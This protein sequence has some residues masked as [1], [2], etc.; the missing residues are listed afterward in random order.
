MSLKHYEKREVKIEDSQSHKAKDYVVSTLFNT[1]LFVMMSFVTKGINLVFNVLIARI[2]TKESYGLATVYFNFIF[3]LLLYFPRET[4]RKTCLKFCPDENE[5]IENFKFRHACHLI[6]L[7]NFLVL[8]CSIPISL[9]FI[10]FAGSGSSR[11]SEYKIHIFIF[12]LSAMI[13]LVAEPAIIYLNVKIDKKYRLIGMTIANYSRLILNY[14]LAYFFG[15]DLWSF[16]LSRLLASIIFAVYIIYVGI[17]IF[18]MHYTAFMPDYQGIVGITKHT[19]IKSLL[20]SFIKGTSLKMILN[21]SERIVLS[22]FLQIS[23]SAKAEYAFVVEN[24]STFIR[25]IIEPAEENFYNLINKIKNYK[26]LTVIPSTG[27]E[28]SGDFSKK[29][30]EILIKLYS[31]L[32]KKGKKDKEN[33]SFKLLKLSLKLFFV[34][35]IL[36]FCY[37]YIIGKD[38][39]TFIFTEKWGTEHTI[40]IIKVYSFY[41]G[42]L[43]ITS[44]TEAYSNATC[45]SEKMSILNSLMVVNAILLVSLSL[46]LSQYDITGLVWANILTLLLRFF[47]NLYLIISNELEDQFNCNK[48]SSLP[49]EDNQ[50]LLDDEEKDS[51]PCVQDLS[52]NEC[53]TWTNILSEMARFTYKSFMKTAAYISTLICL[54]ILNIIKELLQYDDNKPLLLISSGIILSLNVILIFM[55]EKKGFVEIIRLKSSG[56]KI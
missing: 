51:L 4:M 8:V 3:L 52:I 12:V 14:L 48:C 50:L 35:G 31:H 30:N 1:S 20:S 40:S 33:Y 6:W 36:L 49:K 44:L 17:V 55:V 5:E 26:D 38:L 21:Y 23:D 34:F 43:A 47:Y 11:V 46:F 37:M 13:E 39:V 16:T 7:M 2:I 25:F 29:E 42:V 45:S 9:V 27:E 24:F 19:E 32:K 53:I 56:L 10:F 28:F 54:I 15:F 41:V 18:K 22:F